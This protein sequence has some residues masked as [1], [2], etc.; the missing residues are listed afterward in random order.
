MDILRVG[1]ELHG[2]E[3]IVNRDVLKK[4]LRHDRDRVGQIGEFFAGART[5]HGGR[6]GVAEVL[7]GG[8]LED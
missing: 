4:L 6:G 2:I 7:L 8:D 5:G 3:K 1:R